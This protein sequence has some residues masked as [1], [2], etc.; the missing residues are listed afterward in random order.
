MKKNPSCIVIDLG[1]LFTEEYVLQQNQS[2]L[3]EMLVFA[4]V[5]ILHLAL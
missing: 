4:G 3:G 1:V 2:F 5:E